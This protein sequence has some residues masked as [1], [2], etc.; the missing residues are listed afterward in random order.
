MEPGR[1]LLDVAFPFTSETTSQ[2]VSF[3][4]KEDDILP[5][6]AFTQFGRPLVHP[7]IWMHIHRD[8]ARKDQE[9]NVMVYNHE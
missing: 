1:V 8:A 2:S 3:T 4:A 6:N 7:Q 5:L 9:Y